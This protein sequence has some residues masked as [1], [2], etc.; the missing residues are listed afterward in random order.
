MQCQN[1]T[2]WERER[3]I[4]NNLLE[5]I[6]NEYNLLCNHNLTVDFYFMCISLK[7]FSM[8]LECLIYFL[9]CYCF[10][11]LKSTSAI[12]IN[13]FMNKIGNVF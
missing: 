7:L 9:F 4:R 12:L 10:I 5:K 6:R 13:T 2:I 11:A 8:S 1:W 3:Y